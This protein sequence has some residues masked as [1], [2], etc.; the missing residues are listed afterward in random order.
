MADPVDYEAEG[1]L[2]GVEGDEREARRE[3]L[4]VLVADG[5]TLDELKRAVAEDRLALLPVERVLAGEGKYTAGEVAELSGLDPDFQDRLF[6]ALGLALADPD[7]RVYGDEDV[8][9]ARTVT[10]FLEAGF[11][12]DTVLEVCR[13]LGDSMARVAATVGGVVG[14]TLVQPGDTER[15]LGLRYAQVTRELGPQLEPLIVH[16]LKRHQV[17]NAKRVVVSRA[18]IAAGSLRGAMEIG[19]LFADL[20]DFTR[21]GEDVDPAELGQVAGRLTDLALE[22]TVPPVRLVKN[23]GDAVMLVSPRDVDALLETALSLLERAES[24]GEEFPQVRIG[25]ACGEALGRAGDWYGRP[26][27]LASRVTAYARP[28]TILATNEVRDGARGG[29]GWSKAGIRRFK[30]IREPVGL[31]RVRRPEPSPPASQD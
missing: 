8:E 18:D 9:D 2:G 11:S 26:V 13:V 4:D 17:E 24:A 3:L 14:Q 21:L 22:V 30:G 5:A 23:I 28:G 16:V 29:Y 25:I 10:R 19:V 27:N 12:E 6:R 1:L 7:D 15:D 31:L 20:V